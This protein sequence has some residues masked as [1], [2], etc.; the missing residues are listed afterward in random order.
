[1]FSDMYCERGKIVGNV[2]KIYCLFYQRVK[3]KLHF[4]K[5]CEA[6]WLTKP[7]QSVSRAGVRIKKKKRQLDNIVA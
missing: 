6:T 5:K 1:M 7:A 2:N 4:L 3:I